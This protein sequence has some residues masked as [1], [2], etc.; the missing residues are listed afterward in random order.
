MSFSSACTDKQENKSPA[1]GRKLA[2]TAHYTEKRSQSKRWKLKKAYT[3]CEKLGTLFVFAAV[4]QS[5]Q[6]N[7]LAG[8][9]AGVGEK[10]PFFFKIK[11]TRC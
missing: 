7:R 5:L 1:N 10:Q 2:Q 9:Q 4:I 11:D 8:V 6:S 3:Q